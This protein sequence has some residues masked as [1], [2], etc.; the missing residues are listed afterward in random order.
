MEN[1]LSGY[2]IHNYVNDMDKFEMLRSF[3]NFPF[4]LIIPKDKRNYLGE[5]YKE[6]ERKG[7]TIFRKDYQERKEIREEL[8]NTY[9][10]EGED[11]YIDGTWVKVTKIMKKLQNIILHPSDSN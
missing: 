3:E 11:A 2:S 6:M 7:L 9:I 4:N 8:E 1:I 10:E 5:R